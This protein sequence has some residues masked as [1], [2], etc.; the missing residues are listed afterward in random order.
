M[1]FGVG[2]SPRFKT[3]V[4]VLRAFPLVSVIRYSTALAEETRDKK[5]P[6]SAIFRVFIVVLGE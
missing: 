4:V 1:V 5:I 3:F 2:L 6:R